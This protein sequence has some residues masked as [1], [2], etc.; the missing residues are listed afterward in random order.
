[1][2]SDSSYHY[3]RV[4]NSPKDGAELSVGLDDI[5]G[6]KLGAIMQRI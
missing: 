5:D 2:S 6:A 3:Y 4:V 1:M